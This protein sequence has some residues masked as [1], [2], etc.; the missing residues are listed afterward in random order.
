MCVA[1]LALLTLP[2]PCLRSDDTEAEVPACREETINFVFDC[3]QR[4]LG[5]VAR[6][7]LD[8]AACST[9]SSGLR[10]SVVR[11]AVPASPP[12]S[13]RHLTATYAAII[14]RRRLRH[15]LRK[16]AATSAACRTTAPSCQHRRRHRSFVLRPRRLSCAATATMAGTSATAAAATTKLPPPRSRFHQEATFV[17]LEPHVVSM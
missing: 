1:A 5:R 11:R 6:N 13:C 4:R 17:A 15:H 7:A 8:R 3:R 2:L 12:P 16:N 14:L 9:C 10:P